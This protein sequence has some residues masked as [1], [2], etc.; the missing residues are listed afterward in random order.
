MSS[1]EKRSRMRAL[2]HLFTARNKEFYRDYAAMAWNFLFPI[3]VVVGFTFIFSGGNQNVFKVAYQS[4]RGEKEISYLTIPHV[5]FIKVDDVAGQGGA[6][7]KLKRHQYDMVLSDSIGRPEVHYWI[8]ST[9]PKGHLMERILQ[10][11]V[12]LPLKKEIV[13][14]QEIKY[15]DWVIAGLL[16]LNMMFSALFG[17]GYTLVRYR[18]N[19]VL[20]RLKATPLS[21]MTFLLAQVG[22]RLILILS[23]TA[24]VLGGLRLLVNF[25]MQ[26]SYF[27]LFVVYFVGA[28][29]VISLGLLIAARVKSEEFAGGVLNVIS[30]PMM[31][32]SGVWF[33]LEGAPPW[34]QRVSQIF[35]LTHVID[36]ARAIMTEGASLSMLW[37]RLVILAA[38]SVVFLVIGAATFSWD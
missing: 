9:S 31:F 10:G 28:V 35:P 16:A 11:S 23:T 26:G 36:S 38:L 24:I 8:N 14:G 2:W 5:E 33:S 37:P 1:H 18:K 30:W 15:V 13:E 20:K 22:S 32:L 12:E 29:C 34:V 6:L 3:L 17:V 19:G 27:D 25:Q 21:A 4:N 7:E